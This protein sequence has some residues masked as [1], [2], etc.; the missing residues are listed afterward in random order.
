MN[1][2]K[3]I[4]VPDEQDQGRQ[5]ES[6]ITWEKLKNANLDWSELEKKT[7]PWNDAFQKVLLVLLKSLYYRS[8]DTV[9]DVFECDFRFW[10]IYFKKTL[11]CGFE[12]PILVQL[13]SHNF[14]PISPVFYTLSQIKAI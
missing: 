8:C 2:P 9:R 1:D 5:E 4:A 3:K 7:L 12:N 14:H 10:L 11:F 6:A 13:I